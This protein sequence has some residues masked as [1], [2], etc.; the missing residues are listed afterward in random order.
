[1][2]FLLIISLC[3]QQEAVGV[4]E[5]GADTSAVGADNLSGNDPFRL[6]L[7]QQTQEVV[8]VV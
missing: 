6:V 4:V 2:I 7:L 5:D 3:S 1:M 8:G